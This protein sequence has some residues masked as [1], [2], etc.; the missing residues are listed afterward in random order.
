MLTSTDI[1]LSLWKYSLSWSSLCPQSRGANRYEVT[2][3]SLGLS[4]SSVTLSNLCAVSEPLFPCS[5][6]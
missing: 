3:R 6:E 1:A 4:P 5:K 2:L